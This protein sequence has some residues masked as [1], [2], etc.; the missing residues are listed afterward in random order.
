MFNKYLLIALIVGAMTAFAGFRGYELGKDKTNAL[1]LA[2]ELKESIKVTNRINELQTEA[3]AKES[4]ASVKL[5]NI[6]HELT[7][8]KN[9]VDNQSSELNRI[10]ADIKR[11][12]FSES[13]QAV[14][15]EIGT[16]TA[17]TRQCD[18]ETITELSA[19]LFEAIYS[20]FGKCDKITQQL[21]AAQEVIVLDRQI[22]ND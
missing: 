2:K 16:I 10:Y 5:S 22:I 11:L 9:E 18:G 14:G 19:E 7:E 21:N 4:L 8:A 6:Q 3:R 15:S 13:M 17:S 20:E 12:R 1:W